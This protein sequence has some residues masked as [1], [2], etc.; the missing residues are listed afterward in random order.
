MK[1]RWRVFT[2]TD[3][4]TFDDFHAEGVGKHILHLWWRCCPKD[5]F[6]FHCGAFQ[7][8]GRKM[9]IQHA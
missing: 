4:D 6:T 1:P 2:D 9:C 3:R 5:A 8:C 7:H